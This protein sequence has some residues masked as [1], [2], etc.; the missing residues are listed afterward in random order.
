[1]DKQPLF[2][3][4]LWHMH[5]P[6]YNL[7]DSKFALMPWTRFHALK[8][9]ADMALWCEEAGFPATFN[10]VPSMLD[11]I[12]GYAET[13]I[14]DSVLEMSTIPVAD[15]TYRQR[16]F[17]VGHFFNANRVNMINRYP[18]YKR[19]LR[20]KQK[21]S[22]EGS[23]K[24]AKIF[25]DQ[26]I[27]DLTVLQNLA[28]FGEHL[29][30]EPEI[31]ELMDKGENFTRDDREYLLERSRKWI[32]SIIPLYKRLWSEDKIEISVS[33]YYHPILP[34]LCDTSNGRKAD[35]SSS[36]PNGS[37]KY[38]RDARDQIIKAVSRCEELL[39]KTPRGMWPSEG[40]VSQEILPLFQD[41][42]IR[43]I[44]TDEA[45][46]DK[47]L[48]SFGRNGLSNNRSELLYNPYLVENFE[49]WPAMVFRDRG[50]SDA[51]GFHY[52]EAKTSEAIGDFMGKARAIKNSLP[53]DGKSRLLT[54]IMDG[55]NAWEYFKNNGRDFLLGLYRRI[56]EE[57]DLQPTTIGRYIDE[58]KIENRLES[59]QPGSWIGGKFRIWIGAP[60]K[61]RA[62]DE[63]IKARDQFETNK[64]GLNEKV[65]E[66][67]FEDI[68]IAE[69][70]D[71]FWW[72]GDPNYTPYITEF[73][74]LFRERLRK[75]YR[76][77]GKEIPHSLDEPIE[78][79]TREIQ[80]VKRPESSIY[81]SLDGLANSY[82]EWA[83][84]GYYSSDYIPAGFIDIV[85]PEIIKTVYF[86]F[87]TENMYFR[88][89]CYNRIED[90]IE[91]GGVFKIEFRN[92]RTIRIEI[93]RIDNNIRAKIE[94]KEP[95][96]NLWQKI[97]NKIVFDMKDILEMA[98]PRKLFNEKHDRKMKF[99]IQLD[100]NDIALER[101]PGTGFMVFDIPGND[102]YSNNWSA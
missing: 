20:K 95:E 79:S 4:F 48:R 46:L 26:E 71:W 57:P 1:M 78:Q 16:S 66:Q 62:W 42:G 56:I 98:I 89:D 49:S 11:Q 28:W 5:Q 22:K 102:Y 30:S 90:F 3:A 74:F 60:Q 9:Y 72:Y 63:L 100:K 24:S 88:I 45:I 87:G 70:S 84:A 80:P 29:K 69:G 52:A 77:M 86:G 41:S 8:D 54:V 33:P 17:I 10:V 96:S 83:D 53:D 35:K 61:N 75:I 27:L 55:E 2:I 93:S 94:N 31:K 58:H 47:S 101:F 82:M 99:Y 68:M 59:I 6:M 64:D 97:K 67:I 7:P 19:L 92:H 21:N 43:W 34:L 81:P 73:D 37:M 13:S 44:A 40:S 50:L 36:L 12:E 23:F 85:Q 76:D 14:T 65:R 18:A 39:G 38:P 32:A 91:S 15:L 25:T 51:I